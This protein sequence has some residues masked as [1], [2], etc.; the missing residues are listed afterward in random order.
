MVAKAEE[1][2]QQNKFPFVSTW[3]ACT[4]AATLLPMA[5]EGFNPNGIAKKLK[6][7]TGDRMAQT[8]VG[9]L[10]SPTVEACVSAMSALR[11]IK[12]DELMLGVPSEEK[13]AVK[14]GQIRGALGCSWS[15]MELA[16]EAN[17]A[18]A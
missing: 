16:R 9:R 13:E 18:K 2:F 4:I 8:T 7:P 15:K 14:R 10:L 12:V 5:F 11:D 17:K 6:N 3:P 1:I